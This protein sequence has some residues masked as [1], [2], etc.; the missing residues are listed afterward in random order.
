[1][2]CSLQNNYQEFVKFFIFNS[3]FIIINLIFIP[4]SLAGVLIDKIVAIVDREVITWS[5]LYKRM[6]FEYYDKLQS[7][8]PSERKNFLKMYEK[9]YLEKMIDIKVQLKEA[10]KLG[11]SVNEDEINKAIQEI[12]KK[13]NLTKEQFIETIEKQGL[14]FEEYKLIIKEQIIINKLVGYVVR[15]KIMVTEEEIDKY[16]NQHKEEFLSEGYVLRQIFIST[17]KKGYKKKLR[18]VLKL[19]KN[20]KPFDLVAKMYSEGPNAILG[21]KMGFVK[22]EDL[23]KKFIIALDK[24]LEGEYTKPLWTNKGVHILYLEQRIKSETALRD[25]VREK[26]IDI[27]LNKELKQWIRSLRKGYFIEIKL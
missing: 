14:S 25:K 17:E 16:I 5:E 9:D 22:K 12:R 11:I 4:Y 24:L 27:K 18:E 3:I 19:L 15:S 21:G 1:M 13:Y 8:S 23:D 7:L 2:K 20:G 10:E 26:L 6:E